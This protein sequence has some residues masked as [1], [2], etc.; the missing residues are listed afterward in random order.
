MCLAIPA[1]VVVP[2][3]G[4]LYWLVDTGAAMDLERS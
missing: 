2:R 1:Q 3:D 4:A